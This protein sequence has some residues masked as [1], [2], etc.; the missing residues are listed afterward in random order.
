[1]AW[2]RRWRSWAGAILSPIF[3]IS[4]TAADSYLGKAFIVCVLGRAWA[5]L[6]GVL[7]GGNRPWGWWKALGAFSIWGRTIRS[8]CRFGLLLLF[9]CCLR[10]Q[11]PA[12]QE[13]F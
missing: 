5:A 3:P 2:A 8:R 6:P 9:F 11:G 12:G 7:A 1:L 10:P 13:R 4:P